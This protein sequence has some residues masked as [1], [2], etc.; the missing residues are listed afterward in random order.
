MKHDH[1]NR[2]AQPEQRAAPIQRTGP[3]PVE[4][5]MVQPPPEYRV[6]CPHCGAAGRFSPNPNHR[7][8]MPTSGEARRLCLGCGAK[9]AFASDWTRVRVIG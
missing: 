9:L 7:G 4:R 6:K 5:E 3:V 8:T 1:R 2:M